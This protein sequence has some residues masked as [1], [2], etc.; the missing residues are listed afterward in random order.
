MSEAYLTW[1]QFVVSG[2]GI[3]FAGIRLSKYGDMI[4]EKTGLTRNWVGLFLLAMI[5]SLPELAV[6]SSAPFIGAPDI[7]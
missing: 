6:S 4:A 3:V 2:I 7:G 5:T 1:L